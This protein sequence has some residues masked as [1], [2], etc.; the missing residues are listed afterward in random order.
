MSSHEQLLTRVATMYYLQDATMHAI[1]EELGVSRSTISR[2]LKEAR[3]T[4]LVRI[5]V[6]AEPGTDHRGLAARLSRSYGVRAHVVPVRRSISDHR[7][8]SQVARSAAALLA[9]AVQPDWT[10]GVAWGTTISELARHLPARPTPGASVVQLNGAGNSQ[11]S[12]IP[13]VGEVMG[14]FATAFD[15]ETHLFSVPAFFDYAQTKRLLWQERSVRA[16][17]DR[18][19]ACD[20]AVFGVGALAA[21]PPSHVY[22]AGF[23]SDNDLAALQRERIVGDVCTVFLR[24]DG[25]YAD[26]ELN[27]R[28]SGLTPEQLRR[29]PRRLCVAAGEAKIPALRGA[30]RAGVATDLVVDEPTAR[31]LLTRT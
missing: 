29:I 28:A 21:N 26:V 4:G 7:R 13:Y 19:L 27:A 18:Q 25:T 24:E 30:L 11:G 9:E 10:L 2:M 5:S 16:V 22:S 3:E 14:T 6:H 15:A 31:G 17:L 8:L 23:L 1:A 20:V 12:G